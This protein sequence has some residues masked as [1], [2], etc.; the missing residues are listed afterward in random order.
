MP[1]I[2]SR[3]AIRFDSAKKADETNKQ[4]TVHKKDDHAFDSARY[5]FTFMPELAPSVEEI[6]EIKAEQ[7]I[8]LDYGQT[9]AMLRADD[10]V[11]F[12]DDTRAW[13]T[14]YITDFEEV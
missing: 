14:E 5:F 2:S 6:I 11:A 3:C 9:M 7:G 4:E 1:R 10:R 13:D 12:V 8:H